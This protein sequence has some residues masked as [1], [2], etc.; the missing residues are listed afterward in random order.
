MIGAQGTLTD[1]GRLAALDL[2][3]QLAG[4]SMA[5]LYPLTGVVLPETRPFAT[6]GRLH[7]TP[8]RG[9]TGAHWTY[10][11]FTGKVGAS[12]LAGTLR[13]QSGKARPQLQGELVSKQLHL[14]DL[15]PLIGADSNASRA[16][17]GVATVQPA[18]KV[19]PNEKFKT[20]RWTAIDADV[21]FS[22]QR[23]LRD[24]QLP[25]DHLVTH[26]TLKDG[27]LTL[28]PLKF[29][30]AGGSLAAQLQLDSRREPL[31]ADLTL[32]AGQI[33]LKQLFP[34]LDSM[35]ASVGEIHGNAT[36][37]GSGNSVAAL[38]ASTNGQLK[39]GVRDGTVSKFLLEA[40]GLNLGSVVLTQLFGDKQVALRCAVGDFVIQHGVMQTRKFVIDTEDATLR[41]TGAI[42][43]GG[44]QLAL[45][46]VPET[47]GVRLISLRTPLYLTGSFK[48]PQ[49]EVNKGVL[50][51]RAGSALALAVFAP[52]ASAL[53]PLINV[54]ADNNA[55]DD[56]KRG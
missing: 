23:I 54:G 21:R 37:K 43:L 49:V 47:K 40:A 24:K 48:Q 28:S 52:V 45:K 46:I 38:L 12:D 50:A 29:G 6:A 30:I 25:I 22:G 11:N 36:L 2:K 7:G 42:R 18:G 56:D 44:E 41:M 27:V 32:T 16:Q 34:T 15:A 53:I 51:L 9:T 5:Q 13:Y 55:C 8:A 35:R 10:E 1:P 33:K 4:A 17:R 26:L 14:T 3:L 20:G 19:L 31:A 39:L